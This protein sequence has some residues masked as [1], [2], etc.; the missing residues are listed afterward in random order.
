LAGSGAKNNE[1]I[2]TVAARSLRV[3]PKTVWRHLVITT[4]DG[5]V[6]LGEF[7]LDRMPDEID[8]RAL[9]IASRLEGAPAGEEAMLRLG[10]L[11]GDDVIAATIH[12]ACEQALTALAAEAAGEPIWRYLAPSARPGPVPL[13]ANINRRT[14][15]RSPEGFAQSAAKA[16]ATGFAAVKLAPFDALTVENCETLDGADLTEAG[17][18]R[19]EAVVREVDSGVQVM[20]DCHWRFTE[21]AANAVLDR[22]A[23]LGVAWFECPLPEIHDNFEALSALRKRCHERNVRLAGREM[24]CGWDGFRP[25]V[26]AGAY[27]VIMPDIKHAGGHRAIME[28]AD[29]ARDAGVAVSL[30]NPSGPVAHAASLHLASILPGGEALEVQFDE[31]PL[32]WQATSPA[33]PPLGPTSAQPRGPGLG[34]MLAPALFGANGEGAQ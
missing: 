33:P 32:F 30:H 1:R 3:S 7:T 23:A 25:F 10:P 2:G 20:V 27:D 34:V 9:E 4:S 13:Y 24:K 28:I 11:P 29:R 8:A 5:R 18:K 16:I 31:S 26:E 17:L 12:S 14:Q 15:D 21:T 22:L 6:G 19:I